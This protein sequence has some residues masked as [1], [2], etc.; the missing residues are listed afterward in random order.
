MVIV[1]FNRGYQEAVYK[2][3]Y[4]ADYNNSYFFEKAY[5]YAESI[6]EQRS[7]ATYFEIF[8]YKRYKLLFD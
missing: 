7:E 6:L 4:N 8:D 2:C 3:F 5:Q 1:F